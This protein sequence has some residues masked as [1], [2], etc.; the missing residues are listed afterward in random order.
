MPT[1]DG[2][3]VFDPDKAWDNVTDRVKRDEQSKRWTLF[4]VACVNP[5]LSSH[6]VMVAPNAADAFEAAASANGMGGSTEGCTYYPVG[7]TI[8]PEVLVEIMEQ[9]ASEPPEGRAA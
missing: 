5:D 6:G 9:L 4:G 3:Y 1:V 2:K 7:I 8:M